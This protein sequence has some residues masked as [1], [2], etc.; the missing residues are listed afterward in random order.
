MIASNI[1]H[2][3]A[4]GVRLSVNDDQN[5]HPSTEDWGVEDYQPT[6]QPTRQPGPTWLEMVFIQVCCLLWSNHVKI[7]KLSS[8]NLGDDL[9][10]KY[11]V[12]IET[13][14]F[15]FSLYNLADLFTYKGGLQYSFIRLWNG[16]IWDR[17]NNY[18]TMTIFISI[19]IIISIMFK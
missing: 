16:H 11:K 6:N 5:F 12:N 18:N 9:L 4:R 10:H 13:R 17:N 15:R 19:V 3:K 8:Y 1:I 2:C 7:L 14:H